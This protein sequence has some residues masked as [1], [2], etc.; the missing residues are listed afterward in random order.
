MIS[1]MSELN[2]RF[3]QGYYFSEPVEVEKAKEMVRKSPWKMDSFTKY[4]K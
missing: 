3:L 4:L 2:I 1:K